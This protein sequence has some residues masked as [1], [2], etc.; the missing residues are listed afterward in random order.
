MW[1]AQLVVA[2]R[3]DK[4]LA[5][6]FFVG[7]ATDFWVTPPRFSLGQGVLTASGRVAAKRKC[8]NRG[9]HV[10][11]LDSFYASHRLAGPQISTNQGTTSVPSFFIGACVSAVAKGIAVSCGTCRIHALRFAASWAGCSGWLAS[12]QLTEFEG[13]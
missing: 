1:R 2:E 9:P 12:Q 13:Q 6:G 11:C 10:H 5:L 8:P 3:I 7:C 4:N